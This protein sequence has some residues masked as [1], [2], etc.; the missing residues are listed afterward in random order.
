MDKRQKM[1]LADWT[2]SLPDT[3]LISA[4]DV[5]SFF[6]CHVNTVHNKVSA[7]KFPPPDARQGDMRRISSMSRLHTRVFWR[8][9]VL[10][11]FEED[12]GES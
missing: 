7:G 6:G 9:G 3:T 1:V 2:K 4:K 5:A 12:Q 8:L 11:K 10:R